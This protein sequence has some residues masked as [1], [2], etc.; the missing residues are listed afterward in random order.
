MTQVDVYQDCL[1][2]LT[3]SLGDRLTDNDKR[4]VAGAISLSQQ[5][6]EAVGN[7]FNTAVD[8]YNATH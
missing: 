2:K 3:N 8:E 1:L 4:V 6:K 5:E 7:A